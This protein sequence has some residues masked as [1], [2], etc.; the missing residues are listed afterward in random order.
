MANTEVK[1]WYSTVAWR[2]HRAAQLAAEEPLCRM[3]LAAGQI[4]AATVCDHI[5][6]HRGDPDLFWSGP[7]QSLCATCHSLFKQS[8]ERGGVKHLHGCDE[9]G[10]PLFFDW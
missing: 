4:E 6:P 2:K 5:T 10:E 7:F 1:R 3:C 9:Q 8:E